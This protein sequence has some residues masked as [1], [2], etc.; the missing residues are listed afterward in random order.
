MG[1]AGYE[2]RAASIIISRAGGNRAT[3]RRYSRHLGVLTD[4]TASGW[5]DRGLRW[6]GLCGDRWIFDSWVCL[7]VRR[8]FCS[9]VIGGIW[10]FLCMFRVNEA[11]TWMEFYILKRG[12]KVMFLL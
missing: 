11:V 10:K 6:G 9:E 7:H 12:W 5:R 8:N 4:G 2:L 3:A 1:E